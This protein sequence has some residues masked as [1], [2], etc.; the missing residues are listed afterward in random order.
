MDTQAA[1]SAA[2]VTLLDGRHVQLRRL[3]AG[4][5]SAV[6]ALHQNLSDRDRLFR[7]FTLHPR[8]LDE[9]VRQLTTQGDKQTAIGAFE[10]D[11]LIGVA[12]FVVSDDPSVADVA[13]VVTHEEHLHGVGTA[14]LKHLAHL[15]R[16]Q[17]IQRFLADVMAENTLM[18]QVLS[19]FGWPSHRLDFGS[20]LHVEVELPESF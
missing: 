4:D 19:Y 16:S 11:R 15:A 10:D 9:L 1:E 17:G 2:T 14:L 20:V 5:A 3:C 8:H 13:I 12:N 7:F 6:L 18:L